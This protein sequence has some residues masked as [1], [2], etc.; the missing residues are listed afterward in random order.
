M[1]AMAT[2]SRF[3]ALALSASVPLWPGLYGAYWRDEDKWGIRLLVYILN[4]KPKYAV[5]ILYLSEILIVK[6]SYN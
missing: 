1:Q 2:G 3:K 5:N 4:K 6:P